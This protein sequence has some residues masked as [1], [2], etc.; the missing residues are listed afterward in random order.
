M[1]TSFKP[2]ASERIF[3]RG[4]NGL[5]EHIDLGDKRLDRVGMLLHGAMVEHQ[6]VCIRQLGQHR[7]GEVRFGRFL[8]NPKTSVNKLIAATCQGI[9]ER[10][11]DAHVLLIQDT[12]EINYQAHAAR[13]RGLGTVGNGKDKGLFIHPVLSV[14]AHSGACLGLAHVHLWQ[15][16]KAKA[17]NARGLPIEDKESHRWIEAPT[18]AR[19]RLESARLITVV[20]DRESDIFELW[21][22]LP[23]ER[24]HLL[25]RACRDRA[26]EIS[27][28]GTLYSWLGAQPIQGS[29][30][31]KLQARAGK[32]EQHQAL[33]HVRF[34]KTRIMR[35]KGCSDKAAS[36]SLDIW[37]IEVREDA[38][39]VVGQEDAIHWRLL[40]THPVECLEQAM[41]CVQ[42]YC[43]RWHIE[44]TFR[45]LKRQGLDV[46]SSLVEEADRLEK[47]AI[48]ALSAAVH[49]MQLTLARDGNTDR[50]A[51][52]CM[53]ELDYPMLE[54]VGS[55]LEGKTLKQKNPHTKHSL[56][57]A[58]WIVARLGGW[59]GYASERKP[60]PITM[61]HGLKALANI[62]HGWHLARGT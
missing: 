28:Q 31:L 51:S 2:N 34:A 43:Q 1:H 49:T 7:A 23:D 36:A 38:S 10:C 61:V 53:S 52:D 14:D 15:R 29:Y 56:A 12:S 57:W 42:W 5:M 21:D 16:T 40:T 33:M 41:Q 62:R 47:L 50:P 24:T 20:A 58:A 35:P 9:N 11:A 37:A 4:D 32:R 13:V 48:L 22:R 59:K 27:D 55:K 39:T 30:M 8:A 46:E 45:T 25:I 44:Q 19:A 54:Q 6:S 26:L 60:G 18:Q 17:A 3:S